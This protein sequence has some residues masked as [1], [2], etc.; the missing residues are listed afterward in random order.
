M[1]NVSLLHKE[2]VEFEE[3][4]FDDRLEAAGQELAAAARAFS[5]ARS[6]N[7]NDLDGPGA[8]LCKAAAQFIHAGYE[9]IA[10]EEL[11]LV[12]CEC[13]AVLGLLAI[14][15]EA[16][17]KRCGLTGQATLISHPYPSQ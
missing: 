7:I 12:V 10:E 14:A 6:F 13:G 3:C 8:R 1:A 16:T 4:D 15:T 5:T 17:C 2:R 11:V 9:A